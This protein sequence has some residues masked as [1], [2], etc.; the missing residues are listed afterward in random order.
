MLEWFH[1]IPIASTP[2]GPPPPLGFSESSLA[3]VAVAICIPRF[4]R[5]VAEDW[6]HN[7]L[8]YNTIIESN[9]SKERPC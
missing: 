3:L 8:R 6:P 7:V 9:M 5:T 4:A 1:I 2:N